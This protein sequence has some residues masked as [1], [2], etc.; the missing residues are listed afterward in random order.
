M[1]EQPA[2]PA[3]PSSAPTPPSHEGD[4]LEVRSP[5]SESERELTET[6]QSISRLEESN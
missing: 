4:H 2:H 1:S 5:Q 3:D 6:V